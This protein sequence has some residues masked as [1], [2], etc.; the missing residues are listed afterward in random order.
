MQPRPQ[1]KAEFS[2]V[3]APQSRIKTPPPISLHADVAPHDTTAG[4]V[5]A[6][7]RATEEQRE[8]Q[9]AQDRDLHRSS[10][11]YRRPRPTVLSIPP[12]ISLRKDTLED[13]SSW[14]ASLFSSIP[15]VLH[16]SPGSSASTPAAS[17]S[18]TLSSNS[19]GSKH[20]TKPSVTLPTIVLHQEVP[21]EDEDGNEEEEE[22]VEHEY[23]HTASPLYHELMGMMQGQ[24]A[25]ANGVASPGPGSPASPGFQLETASTSS[26]GTT[27]RD[28]QLTIRFNPRRDSSRDS[29]AST[30][31]LTHATIVRGASIV[32]RVRA[33][34]VTT[35]PAFSTVKGKERGRERSPVRLVEIIQDEDDVDDGSDDNEGDSSSDD[36]GSDEDGASGSPVGTLALTS[37]PNSQ[38]DSGGCRSLRKV[39]PLPSPSPSPL[40]ASFPAP[41]NEGHAQAQAQKEIQR[42]PMQ[43]PYVTPP[44]SAPPMP[45][46]RPPLPVPPIDVEGLNGDPTSS[47]LTEHTKQAENGIVLPTF[48]STGAAAPRYPAW[49]A[50]VVLPLAEFIDDSADPRVLFTDLQEIAQGESGSVYSARAAPTVAPQ[51]RPPTPRSPASGRSSPSSTS[52]KEEVEEGCGAR[53]KQKHALVAIKRVPLLPGG[54]EKLMDLRRELEFARALRHAN[55]LRMEQ[56]YVDVVEESLW[57]GMELLD[58][59]LAD[60]LAVVG[61]DAGAGWLSGS[62]S[63]VQEG[64]GTGVVEISE[65]MV[66]RFVWDVSDIHS[67]LGR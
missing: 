44:P 46:R 56:L 54:T 2:P 31:T 4:L 41:I 53:Q 6:P 66:A 17:A 21:E 7:T 52:E 33:D 40:R 25:A 22:I 43:G 28:S 29:S 26:H 67:F 30:N 15:S 48:T 14:S 18:T 51:F 13:L 38:E 39:S 49:L 12:R 57:I 63:E 50:A 62:D 65:R 3:S 9:G 55:V 5:E 36:A 59:S 11:E 23:S 42:A 10:S 47:S 24:A 58:R 20:R 1:E 61:E 32:R 64:S 27:S 45:V 37:A 8:G 34:V 19:G 60:V 16:D 35:P